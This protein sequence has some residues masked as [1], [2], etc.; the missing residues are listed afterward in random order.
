MVAVK[1]ERDGAV[2]EDLDPDSV[3]VPMRP[4]A[5]PDPRAIGDSPLD[6]PPRVGDASFGVD[7][8]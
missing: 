4:L 6:F 3:G 5:A 7:D 2:I 1:A 8:P